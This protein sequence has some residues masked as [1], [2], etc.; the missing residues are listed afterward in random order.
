MERQQKF[1]QYKKSPRPEPKPKT[2]TSSQT[3]EGEFDLEDLFVQFES[4]DNHTTFSNRSAVFG[5]YLVFYSTSFI[6]LGFYVHSPNH[7]LKFIIQIMTSLVLAV[8]SML[9]HRKILN[10]CLG[11]VSHIVSEY[12]VLVWANAGLLLVVIP[13]LRKISGF[14][15]K[16]VL[17]SYFVS[18]S[19]AC[20]YAAF[21]SAG[22][23][24]KLL[25]RID[26]KTKTWFH[27][28]QAGLAFVFLLCFFAPF[29]VFMQSMASPDPV[30]FNNG[31]WI[32][33]LACSFVS[34]IVATLKFEWD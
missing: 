11:L 24:S 27:I 34:L 16:D 28:T 21:F 12:S 19:N 9:I 3:P 20:L 25:Q 13:Y 14:I 6:S 18:S 30:Y 15:S 8:I 32:S 31:F 29:L 7:V 5:S 17:E 10:R 23:I 33:L 22:W 1:H 2:Q 26:F 4:F